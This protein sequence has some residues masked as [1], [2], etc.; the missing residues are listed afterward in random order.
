MQ[1]QT[2]QK[3]LSCSQNFVIFQVFLP[4][5]NVPNQNFPSTSISQKKTFKHFCNSNHFLSYTISKTKIPFFLLMLMTVHAYL[6]QKFFAQLNK[7][8]TLLLHIPSHS[9]HIYITNKSVLHQPRVE[10]QLLRTRIAYKAK[11]YQKAATGARRYIKWW[12]GPRHGP[13]IK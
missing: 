2:R 4:L 6:H 8:R 7:L 13:F 9:Q 12:T 11:E 3:P 5:I 10:S 1:F